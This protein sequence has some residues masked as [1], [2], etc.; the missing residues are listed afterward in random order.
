MSVP[1]TLPRSQLSKRLKQILADG[2]KLTVSQVTEA[3][4][5]LIVQDISHLKVKFSE[6]FG[7]QRSY[8]PI[9][10]RSCYVILG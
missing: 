6:S 4:L 3:I 1:K 5:Q 7:D 2:E 10:S 9:T 8:T